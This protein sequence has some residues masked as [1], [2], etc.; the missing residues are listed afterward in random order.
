M[1][2]SGSGHEGIETAALDEKRRYAQVGGVYDQ[3]EQKFSW[4]GSK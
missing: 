4:R 1:L 2:W 3:R